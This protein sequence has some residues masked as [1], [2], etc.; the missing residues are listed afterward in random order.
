MKKLSLWILAAAMIGLLCGCGGTKEQEVKIRIPAGSTAAYVFSDEEISPAQGVIT[1][2]A[3]VGITDTGVILRNVATGKETDS[4]YLTKGM[5]VTMDAEKKAWYQVGVAL[6]NPT[7]QDLV[8]SVKIRGAE[9][10]IA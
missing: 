3:G 5:P 7:E 1:L 8:V 10:R 2:E 6:E 4:V 9:V